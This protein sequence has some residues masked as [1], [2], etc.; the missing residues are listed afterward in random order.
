MATGKASADRLALRSRPQHRTVYSGTSALVTGPSGLL[1][2]S[3]GTGFYAAGTRMLSRLEW[4][5][6]GEPFD[7]T[8]FSPIGNDRALLYAQL[9]GSEHLDEHAPYTEVSALQAELTMVV[10]AGLRIRACLSNTPRSTPTWSCSC[11]STRTSPARPRRRPVS[12]ISR[13][14]SGARSTPPRGR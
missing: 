1:D 6:D 9:A 7:P 14:R 2:Q 3:S 13:A 4:L 12:A 5:C 10:G 8:A 11:S